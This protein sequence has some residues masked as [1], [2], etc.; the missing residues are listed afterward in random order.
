MKG[1]LIGVDIG[2]QGTK[3][4]LADENLRILATSFEES[5]LMGG[6]SGEVWQNA[7]DLYGS[8][9]RTIRDIVEKSRIP[10]ALIRGIGVDSQ[11]AGIMGID[12]RGEASTYY[13]SWLDGRCSK[14]IPE[15]ED[16]AG[17]EILKCSGG[18]VTCA[19]APKIVWWSREHPD[20]YKKTAKFV[21][22]HGY[23]SGKMT[24]NCADSAVF[25]H[26]CL[27]FNGFSDNKR[28]CWNENMLH[29]F[30]IDAKKMPRI[31]S[32]FEVIGNT[33][34]EFAEAAG[35]ISGI[36]VVAG[37]GDTA[38]S[39]FG[40]GMFEKGKI[41][42]CAGTASILSGVVEEY[43]PDIKNR[44]LI[45][46]RSPLEDIWLPLAYIAGG[47]MCIRWMRD[48]IAKVNSYVVLEKEAEK[49]VPGCEGLM[50]NPHFSGRVLPPEPGMKGAFIGL[51]FRHTRAH[52]YRAVF[53]SIACEYAIYLKILNETFEED[54]F[55]QIISVGGGA[56]SDL[57]NQIKADVLGVPVETFETGET[58]L[59]GSAAVAGIAVGLVEDYKKHTQESMSRKRIYFPDV[60]NKEIYQ[61]KVV[62]HQEM[63]ELLKKWKGEL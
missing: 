11:M 26:T 43:E 20:I 39:T 23:V 10:P 15:M 52:M 5:R 30:G 32:P 35:V 49:I 12:E 45:M 36:P 18:P 44:T 31:V 21:L 16:K 46:M 41:L 19:Q 2:T 48:N 3:A 33:S 53:E 24:G 51:D 1:Y 62:R 56:D 34:K 6:N 17:E 4:A 8:C 58:A 22:P 60:R 61:E 7:E 63:L 13:D 57:L 50:F 25:D 42:D 29:F 55:T 37:L 47:G 9:V 40:S 54:R 27:H 38:A 59:I 28:R 14:Y